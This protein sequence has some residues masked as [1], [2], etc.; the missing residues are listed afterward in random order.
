MDKNKQTIIVLCAL[1]VVAGF[2]FLPGVFKKG[3]KPASSK[4]IAGLKTTTDFDKKKLKELIA[5]DVDEPVEFINKEWGLRD[6]F[7]LTALKVLADNAIKA[8]KMASLEVSAKGVSAETKV[9][10]KEAAAKKVLV[11]TGVTWGGARPS[12]IINNVYVGVGEVVDG[13]IVTEIRESAV[14]LIED[15]E[16]IVLTMWK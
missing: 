2:I 12:A 10:E 15:G 4:K 8:A 5:A 1:I 6:P 14:V 9:K 3:R 11:L 16:E 13:C 7:D